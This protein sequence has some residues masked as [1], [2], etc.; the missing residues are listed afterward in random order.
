MRSSSAAHLHEQA[1]S[2]ANSKALVQDMNEHVAD[3]V[4]V[5][6]FSMKSPR[7]P[8]HLETSGI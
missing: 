4:V 6:G 3:L 7:M 1:N 5:D 2:R 8:A